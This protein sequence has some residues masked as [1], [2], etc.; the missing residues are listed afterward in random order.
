MNGLK[1]HVLHHNVGPGDLHFHYSGVGDLIN[2]PSHET[3]ADLGTDRVDIV[4]H[5]AGIS[6]CWVAHGAL[7]RKSF[8]PKH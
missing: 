1:E 4:E 2:F 7:R 3:S 6:P 8:L 5:F